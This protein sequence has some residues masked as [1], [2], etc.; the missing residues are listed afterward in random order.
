MRET[1]RLQFFLNF[2]LCIC[3]GIF[4][5]YISKVNISTCIGTKQVLLLQSW[6]LKAH[7]SVPANSGIAKGP[8]RV[9]NIK[10][11]IVLTNKNESRVTN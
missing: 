2:I 3:K 1:P 4:L 6:H 7:G 8:L 10:N 5:I 9:V 11:V